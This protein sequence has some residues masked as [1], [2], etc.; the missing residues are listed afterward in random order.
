M[1]FVAV[2]ELLVDVLAQ[3]AGHEARIRL[4]PAGSAFNAA[5]AARAAGADTTVR[6]TVGDDPAGR[7][8]LTELEARGVRTE[9]TV[10]N[11]PT[12]TFLLMGDEVRV[13]RGVAHD[14]A[15]P[16]EIDADIVLVSGYIPGAAEALSR[17]RAEWV[18]LDAA[19]LAELP[20]GANAVF[21]SA[22]QHILEELAEGRRLAVRTQGPLGAVA[23]LDGQI[24]RIAPRRVVDSGPGAGD[25]FAATLLVALARG[26]KLEAALSEASQ[27]ALDSLA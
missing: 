7:L 3:G 17:A 8:I 2:G 25:A 20:P 22:P 9:V 18:A 26:D 10:A 4:G 6:G 27:A 19:N 15:L 12:G 13:D 23:M 11:G 16:E 21:S 24:G 5:V 1:R 14:I